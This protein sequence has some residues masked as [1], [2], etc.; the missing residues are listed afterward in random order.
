MEEIKPNPKKIWW[1]DS[2]MYFMRVSGWIAGPVIFSLIV[3]KW[4]DTR[5]GTDPW[6]FLGLTGFGFM[7][8]LFGLLKETKKY[9]DKT[10]ADH[11]KEQKETHDGG[12]HT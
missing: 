2:M 3:G 10:V 9:M 11:K 12:S 7:I 6:I 1:K 8:S 4:L 5:F